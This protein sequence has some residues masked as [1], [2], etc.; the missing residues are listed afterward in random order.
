[1]RAQL[2]PLLDERAPMDAPEPQSLVPSYS[3]VLSHLRWGWSLRRCVDIKQTR[4]TRSVLPLGGGGGSGSLSV[5]VLFLSCQMSQCA[6]SAGALSDS[7]S[8][9]VRPIV[10]SNFSG[11]VSGGSASL[12]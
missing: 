12:L 4:S 3:C 9:L 10:A 8:R 2:N 5:S 1:M 11:W 7:S 6:H